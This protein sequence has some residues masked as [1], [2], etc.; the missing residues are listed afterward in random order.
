MTL[1]KHQNMLRG[2]TDIIARKLGNALVAPVIHYVPPDDGARGEFLGD[3]NISLEAYKSTLTDISAP[4]S[5]T[6]VSR[7]SF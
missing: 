5:R 2:Q 1:D 6:M 7:M 3:F 4:P